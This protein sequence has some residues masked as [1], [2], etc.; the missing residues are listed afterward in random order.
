MSPRGGKGMKCGRD[1]TICGEEREMMYKK[2]NS[3][4]NIG[5]GL[6]FVIV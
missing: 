2:R 5:A 4:Y 3:M 1:K 6:Y